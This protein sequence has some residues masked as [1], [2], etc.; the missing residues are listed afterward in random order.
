MTAPAARSILVVDDN[1]AVREAVARSLA[2]RGCRVTTAPD[3]ERALELIRDQVFDA[4]VTDFHMPGQ[5]GLWL[6]QQAIRTRPELRSRFVLLGSEPLPEP[7]AREY[8]T[9]SEWLLPKP[10]TLDALWHAVDAIVCRDD[11][12]RRTPTPTTLPNTPVPVPPHPAARPAP[13][14]TPAR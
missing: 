6:W 2:R 11:A 14:P 5:T 8:F 13:S 4:V 7:R 12:V 3:A 9:Q 1:L 10:F